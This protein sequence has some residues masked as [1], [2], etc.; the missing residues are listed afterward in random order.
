MARERT[1][2]RTPAGPAHPRRRPRSTGR[3]ASAT[4]PAPADPVADEPSVRRPP[5][6]RNPFR[7][8]RRAIVLVAVMSV[9]GLSFVGSLRVYILQERDLATARQQITDRTARVTELESELQ[10][11][12]DPAFVKAQARTRLGWVMPGDI[13]YRVIGRDGAILSGGSE[14]V[15]I[16]THTSSDFDPRWWDRLAGSIKAAD[17]PTPMQ[18]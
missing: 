11:W 4:L 15:G 1:P 5:R 6:R 7:V 8:T 14:I 2:A 18:P 17:D 9:L 16:G 3:T 12:R 13:G 10:R